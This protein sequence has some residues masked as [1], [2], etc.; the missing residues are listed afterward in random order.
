MSFV[1]EMELRCGGRPSDF[2]S[3]ITVG[4]SLENTRAR[5]R[6]ETVHAG[7]AGQSPPG[8]MAPGTRMADPWIEHLASVPCVCGRPGEVVPEARTPNLRAATDWPWL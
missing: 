4:L 7:L 1:G 5:P 2:S 3:L 6:G 8:H